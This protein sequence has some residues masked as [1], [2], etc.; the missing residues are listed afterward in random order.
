M[1]SALATLIDRMDDPRI[2]RSGVIRWGAPVPSFGDLATSTVATLG[3]N[4][5]NREFVDEAGNELDGW[6]RRFHTLHSL[7]LCCWEDASAAHLR[8]I[9]ASC[10]NYFRC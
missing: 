5:S 1:H 7:G 2:T 9:L 10:R 3:L 4:P 8:M 6:D